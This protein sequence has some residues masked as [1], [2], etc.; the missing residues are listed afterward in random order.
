MKGGIIMLYLAPGNTVRA[1]FKKIRLQ[2][3]GCSEST[4]YSIWCGRGRKHKYEG[5]RQDILTFLAK[6]ARKT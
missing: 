2:N 6:D 5:A 1:A 3:K 4:N